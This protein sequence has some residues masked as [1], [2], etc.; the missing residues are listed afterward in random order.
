MRAALLAFVLLVPTASAFPG[1]EHEVDIVYP[2]DAGPL[3]L[4]AG[5]L[6]VEG[7]IVNG[8]LL[9]DA[10]G[11][12]LGP[13]PTLVVVRTVDGAPERHELRDAVVAFSA[14][15]VLVTPP[16]AGVTL[17]AS[18]PYGVAL[19][20]A[21]APFEGV[22][23]A[24][25]LLSSTGATG[26]VGLPAGET[27]LVPLEAT[28]SILRADG[29]AFDGWADVDAN[30]G[31][32]TGDLSEGGREDQLAF[33][34][35]LLTAT[36]PFEG[37]VAA[38][39][40]AGSAGGA[41]TLELT[42]RRADDPRFLDALDALSALPTGSDGGGLGDNEQARQVE[43]ISDIFNGGALLMNVAQGE[44]EAPK[45]TSASISGAQTDVGAFSLVRGEGLS[46]AWQG[47]EMRLHGMAPLVVTSAGVAASDVTAL[48]P[49]PIVSVVMWAFAVIALVLFFAKRPEKP[50]EKFW[51]LRLGSLA[52]HL[53]VLAGVFWWWDTQFAETTGTSFLTQLA[54]GRAFDMTTLGAVLALQLVPWGLL[55]LLF[56]MPVR[57]IAGVGLRYAK[58][59]TA[60]KGLAKSAGLVTLAILGP[61]YALWVTN[62]L[63]KEAIAA[64]T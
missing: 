22:K 17:A 24:G 7:T 57:I 16:A 38:K 34:G 26:T 39:V 41:G 33:D 19:G 25:F 15:A 36:G 31:R 32:T 35:I 45:P 4:V 48:G 28:L 11:T 55:A 43:P 13:I 52:I 30:R 59:G 8:L 14:G 46:L 62:Y 44:R 3:A 63:L 47:N 53:L 58:K 54:S 1:T 50:Q 37:A 9:G 29:T 61:F 5:A 10:G 64:M 21:E 6:G 2:A 51:S 49:F 56:A 40:L 60:M 42:T 27:A 23:S 12:R 20:I 18:A